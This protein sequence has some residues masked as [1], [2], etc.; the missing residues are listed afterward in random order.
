MRQ[1]CPEHFWTANG[2]SRRDEA[3]EEPNKHLLCFV[4]RTVALQR[5]KVFL[6][7]LSLCEV[8]EQSSSPP[9]VH[10]WK[11]SPAATSLK[12]KAYPKR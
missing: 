7:P 11:A 2:W 5:P 3:H 1:K 6:T 8:G 9:V 10:R 12:Q 4:L